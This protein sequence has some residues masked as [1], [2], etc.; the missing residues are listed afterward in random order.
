MYKV[1]DEHEHKTK[2]N[3]KLLATV[4]V[5]KHVLDDM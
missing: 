5:H 3:N 1:I 2:F 4:M